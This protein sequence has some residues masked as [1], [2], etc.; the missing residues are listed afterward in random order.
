MCSSVG[1]CHDPFWF[2]LPTLTRKQAES[3][4]CGGGCAVLCWTGRR[5]VQ[6][7]AAQPPPHVF[8]RSRPKGRESSLKKD[9]GG[10]AT[11]VKGNFRPYKA[12][13]I[14]SWEVEYKVDQLCYV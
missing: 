5:P 12:C 3:N 1:E 2:L 14:P 6:H 4:V 9:Q 11:R 7:N 10:R 8:K 13:L